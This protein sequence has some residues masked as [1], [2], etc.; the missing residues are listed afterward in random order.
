MRTDGE[1]RGPGEKGRLR[2]RLGRRRLFAQGHRSSRLP[3]R[4]RSAPPLSRVPTPLPIP[5]QRRVRG[6]TLLGDFWY[7]SKCAACAFPEPW[8]PPA[9]SPYN[10]AGHPTGYAPQHGSDEDPH[11]A[12]AVPQ[13]GTRLSG[14]LD[15]AVRAP[16]R[17]ER[18]GNLCTK[19]RHSRV[20]LEPGGTFLKV[21]APQSTYTPRGPW[22]E[23]QWSQASGERKRRREAKGDP[24]GGREGNRGGGKREPRRRRDGDADRGP[25]GGGDRFVYGQWGEG[26]GRREEPGEGRGFA[27]LL[28]AWDTGGTSLLLWQSPRS[29]LSVSRDLHPLPILQPWR[30]RV[31][32]PTSPAGRPGA[33]ARDSGPPRDMGRKRQL[34][35][36]GPALPISRRSS[37]RFFFPWPVFVTVAEKAA[38][39]PWGLRQNGF[40][41][42]LSSP[43]VILSPTGSLICTWRNCN[44]WRE[45]D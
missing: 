39:R 11:H 5:P 22:E 30:S 13:P 45:Q 18:T 32:R 8:R 21:G 36:V 16:E 27:A 7:P 14:D 3:S 2:N 41:S 25:G 23:V 40:V 43:R 1:G 37:P 19:G 24:E 38:A 42:L 33:A 29:M 44:I 17:T 12:S 10:L 31:S 9:T 28:P 26:R 34:L 4:L 6:N 35:G 20:D 15:P